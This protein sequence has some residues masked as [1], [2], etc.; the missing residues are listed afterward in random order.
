MKTLF[1]TRLRELR[2]EAGL[3]QKQLA[4]RLGITKTT[5]NRYE[6]DLREPEFATL[7]EIV[8]FFGVSAD[9]LL[10]IKDSR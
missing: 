9:Y 1:G 6:N 3:S 10:G 7:I 4:E 2:E 8:R 5:V